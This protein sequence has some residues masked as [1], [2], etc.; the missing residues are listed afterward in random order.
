MTDD[1]IMTNVLVRYHAL[2][3]QAA[4]IVRSERATAPPPVTLDLPEPDERLTAFYDVSDMSLTPLGERDGRRLFLLDLMRN[5]G[6]MTTK[7]PASLLMVA[8]AAAHV[9]ATGERLIIVTPTSG[10]KGT[11]LRDAV[12]R[13][14]AHGLVTPDELR[15]VIVV[16]ERSRGKLRACPLSRDPALS[17]AN[18]IALARVQTPGDVKPLS[19]RAVEAYG[20]AIHADTGFRLW[21]TLDLDNYRIADAARAFAEAE[22]MP[23]TPG[24]RPRVHAHAVS[25]AYGLLGYHLGHRVLTERRPQ[26]LPAP[27]RHPG[28]FLIQQLS[29]PDMVLSL[30]KGGTARTLLPRYEADG[31]LWRQSA[32]PAFPSVTEDPAEEIDATFYTRAPVTS[33]QVNRIIGEFGGGGVVVSRYECVQRY[34]TVRAL[35]RQAGVELPGDPADIREW[36]LVKALAGALTGIERGLLAPGTDVIVHAS[37]FYSDAVLPPL[38]EHETTPVDGEDELVK[39]LMAAAAG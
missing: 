6:T 16:P 33:P 22:L 18:P 4:Q 14:Y 20:A 35:A 29:T 30:T 9:R 10:N 8:R 11:A 31:G 2:L 5:P 37:G 39:L 36:S 34:D 21:Y 28:F 12:A 3:R 13:A 23:I 19:Q 1:Q 27:A 38:A 26:S 32:D 17:A 7:T 25:S 24:S 15:V